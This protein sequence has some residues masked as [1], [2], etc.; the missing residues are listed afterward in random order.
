MTFDVWARAI[1]DGVRT[2]LPDARAVRKGP[3]LVLIRHADREAQLVDDGGAFCISFRAGHCAITMSGLVDPD[4]CDAFTALQSGALRVRWLFRCAVRSTVR[5]MSP[6][7][8]GE[9]IPRPAK[10]PD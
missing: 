4:R 2:R 9:P 1:V 3:R 10:A 8:K 6:S 7:G 5:L